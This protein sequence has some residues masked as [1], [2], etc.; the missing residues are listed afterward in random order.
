MTWKNLTSKDARKKPAAEIL[1]A[2]RG[3]GHGIGRVTVMQVRGPVLLGSAIARVGVMKGLRPEDL[4]GA[5]VLDIAG[6]VHVP[7]EGGARKTVVE[8]Q[9]RVFWVRT[10]GRST[11]G[12]MFLLTELQDGQPVSSSS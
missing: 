3:L 12:S 9:A 4:V 11:L 1:R 10:D 7:L 6:H 8:T 5:I 2:L